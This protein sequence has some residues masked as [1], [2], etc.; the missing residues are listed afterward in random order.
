MVRY[1]HVHRTFDCDPT[2]TD[3]QVLDFCRNG[4]LLLPGVV[5]DAINRRTCDYLN[6]TLPA[7]PSYIPDGLTLEDLERIRASHE[8]STILLEEWFIDHVL[9]NLQ[10]AGVLRSLLGKNAGLPVLV[11]HHRVECPA[12]AQG[13]HYDADHLFGPEINF[14]EVFYFPQDTPLELG[15]TELVSGSHLSPI[16]REASDKGVPTTGPAGTIGIHL[17]NILHRRG[18]STAAGIRHMLKYSYW[19]TEPPKRDWITEPTFDFR[20]VSY[21]GHGTARYVAHMFYWLCGKGKEYR[22]IGGQAWPWSSKNQ[23]GPSYGF[24]KT[25]G[26]LPNWRKNNPDDY[27]A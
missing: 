13:W 25:E 1:D 11:S 9:L 12:A 26:Y 27:A 20:T 14:V 7:Q 8:P 3:T 5:P 22:I 23:I 10:V 15:P 4:F 19:R 18:E 6:G 21:G 16:R 24:G 17:Q 2:L